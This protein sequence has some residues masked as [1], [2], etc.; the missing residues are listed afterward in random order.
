MYGVAARG[1]LHVL[2]SRATIPLGRMADWYD[3]FFD[4]PNSA[5][6]TAAAVPRDLRTSILNHNSCRTR[7]RS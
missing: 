5:S 3:G 2:S 6:T 1:Y 7:C 4:M